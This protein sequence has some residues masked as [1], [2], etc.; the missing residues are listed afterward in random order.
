MKVEFPLGD[1]NFRP[2]L[3]G[4][5]NHSK[6]YCPTIEEI[7]KACIEIRSKWD[8]GESARRQSIKAK[9]DWEVPTYSNSDIEGSF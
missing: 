8:D 3:I 7:Q 1:F 4:E 5:V 9:T 6:R 2:E